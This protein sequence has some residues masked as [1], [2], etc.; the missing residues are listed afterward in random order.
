M[1]VRGEE[2]KGYEWSEGASEV[3]MRIGW[4]FSL[5]VED[6]GSQGLEEREEWLS[7]EWKLSE[8]SEC[9]LIL[10]INVYFPH[11]A[12]ETGQ[13][14]ARDR[15]GLESLQNVWVSLTPLRPVSSLQV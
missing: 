14:T 6:T 3:S 11:Y 5:G 4:R 10:L 1:F 7:A 2:V 8:F 13:K 9:K 12:Y 15:A